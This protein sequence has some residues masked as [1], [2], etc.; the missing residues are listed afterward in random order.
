MRV[1]NFARLFTP[2]EK[3]SIADLKVGVIRVGGHLTDLKNMDVYQ[4]WKRQKLQKKHV[5]KLKN[6][7]THY[8]SIFFKEMIR[9]VLK[10]EIVKYICI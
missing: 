8:F 9:I 6:C 1:T 7:F 4:K 2:G 10:E 3:D 5:R